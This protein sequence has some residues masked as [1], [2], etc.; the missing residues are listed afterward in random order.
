MEKSLFEDLSNARNRA[1][2]GVHGTTIPLDVQIKE[3]TPP[4]AYITQTEMNSPAMMAGIQ[5]GDIITAVNGSDIA[6]F[7]QLVTKLSQCHPEDVITVRVSRQAPNNFVEL[8]IEVTLTSA[9]HN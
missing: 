9:T 7:E 1:Y 4:G 8:D 5:S 2:L 3:N 6:S